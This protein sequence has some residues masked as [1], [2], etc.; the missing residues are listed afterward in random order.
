[1]RYKSF[2]IDPNHTNKLAIS[3]GLAGRLIGIKFL[4]KINL[5]FALKMYL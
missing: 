5:H 4:L 1:M 2:L 3:L